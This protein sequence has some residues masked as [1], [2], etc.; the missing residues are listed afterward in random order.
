MASAKILVVEDDTPTLKLIVRFLQHK[1]YQ[2]QMASNGLSALA[3]FDNFQPDLVILDINLPDVLGYEICEQMQLKRDV[4]ILILTCRTQ[5]E[6]IA[7]AFRKGADDYITKPFHLEEL[8]WRI[9]ALL[10]RRRNNSEQVLEQIIFPNLIIDPNRREII[11]ND[12]LLNVTSLEFELIYFLA[13]NSE[14]VWSRAELIEKVWKYS[15]TGDHRVVDVH[16]GQIR[17]KLQAFLSPPLF[18]QTVR[19]IGYK[20]EYFKS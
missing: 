6:D 5:Q 13:S 18:I 8:Q 3:V 19:G 7:E 20:F 15:F 11:V 1:S 17:K 14:R 16:I 2:L 9:Q 4:C 10:K 12:Q